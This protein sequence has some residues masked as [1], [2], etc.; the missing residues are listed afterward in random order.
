[1]TSGRAD[2][3]LES[4]S[5]SAGVASIWTFGH[6]LDLLLD[7]VE[8]RQQAR[9]EDP[10]AGQQDE[11]QDHRGRRGDAHQRVPPEALPGAPEAEATNDTIDQSARW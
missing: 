3:C 4:R 8:R 10:E 9:L 1:M 7:E 5:I 6:D 2:P 11:H